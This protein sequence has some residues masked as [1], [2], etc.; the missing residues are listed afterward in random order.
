MNARS[1]VQAPLV[2]LGVAAWGAF[3]LLAW[4][5]RRGLTAGFDAAIERRVAAAATPRLERLGDPLTSLGLAEV[6]LGLA[7]ALGLV[8]LLLR[9]SRLALA[10]ALVWLSL[11]VE[12]ALKW[13]L[14]L[15]R[16]EL[17]P[18]GAAVRQA[19]FSWR[20]LSLD[21]LAEP[22]GSYPS[23]H[24]VRTAF[25]AGL[26]VLVLLAGRRSWAARVAAL[27]A[28][29]AAGALVLVMGYT[30]VLTGQHTPTDVLGGYLLALA[31]LLPA[32][33]LLRDPGS[34]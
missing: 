24:V 2:A 16:S 18:L 13:W 21:D 28:V 3:A 26:L 33:L 5:A 27:P 12:L 22:P 32:L 34:E 31:L 19:L 14:Y 7:L 15:P 17:P 11:P 10:C 20:D 6:T 29:S 4:L 30:R 23:G 8:A 25:L 1:P 9:R